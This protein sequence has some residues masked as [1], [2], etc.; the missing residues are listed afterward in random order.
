MNRRIIAILGAIIFVVSTVP[1]K[2]EAG[3]NY[4]SQDEAYNA[5]LMMSNA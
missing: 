1:M 4:E 3:E 5:Y 2:V